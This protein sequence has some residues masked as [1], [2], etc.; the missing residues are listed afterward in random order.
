MIVVTH[1]DLDG[2]GCALVAQY[3]YQKQITQ[4]IYCDYDTVD[5]VL[6]NLLKTSQEKILMADISMKADTAL[7]IAQNYP[8]RVELFDHHKTTLT[9][10]TQYNWAHIDITLSATRLLFETLCSRHPKIKIHNNLRK[11]VFHANDY[12]LWIHE[13]PQSA[14]FNDL[15][16]LLGVELFVKTMFP[17]LASGRHLIHESD[18][19]Y[20]NALQLKKEIFFKQRVQ[21][22]VV[23]GNRLIVIAARHASELSQYIRD[24]SPAPEAWKNV[25][26]IDIINLENYSHSLRSY[27]PDFDVSQVAVQHG[28]GGHKKAAGYQIDP[29]VNITSLLTQL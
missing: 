25:D 12:D 18:Q 14:L 20:L 1:I 13:S 7:M 3:F 5:T 9:Y 10:L 22:A 26:Y 24:I 2:A 28:G 15:V 21:Q 11:I 27:N 4:T 29:S 19:L 23:Q 8:D 6:C 17:R 16:N